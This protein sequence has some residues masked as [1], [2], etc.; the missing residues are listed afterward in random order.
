M[1]HTSRWKGIRCS[2]NKPKKVSQ[3]RHAQK[4]FLQRAG[5]WFDG[6]LNTLFIKQIQNGKA[7]FVEKQSHRVSV[8]LIPFRANKYKCVYDKQR[9]QIVTVLP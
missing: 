8:W 5:F 6:S 4:R 7:E 1:R 3:N 2:K 9:K